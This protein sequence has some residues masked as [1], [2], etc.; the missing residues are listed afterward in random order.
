MKTWI[1]RNC[2]SENMMNMNFCPV[3]HLPQLQNTVPQPQPQPE[4]PEQRQADPDFLFRATPLGSEPPVRREPVQQNSD[5]DFLF[6]AM[7][8]N[9]AQ[10][11]EPLNNAPVRSQLQQAFVGVAPTAETAASQQPVFT[12]IPPAEASSEPVQ[13]PFAEIAQPEEPTVM[14][15]PQP[16]PDFLFRAVQTNSGQAAEEPLPESEQRPADPDFL[17]AA[18]QTDAEPAAPMQQTILD[19]APQQA[20]AAWQLNPADFPQ[21]EAPAAP[22]EAPAAQAAETVR[23]AEVK[24]LIQPNPA[25]QER[26]GYR[27]EPFAPA[28]DGNQKLRKILIAANAALLIANIIGLILW[29]K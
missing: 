23:P 1:C 10:P 5:P 6:R 26:T 4:M 28:D 21:P 19:R 20:E 13:Q 3:C 17:F 29:L 27:S 9:E 15:Q 25:S 12:D 22:Q 7:Q 14:E 8:E 2:N 18:V 11:P 16:D 24:P